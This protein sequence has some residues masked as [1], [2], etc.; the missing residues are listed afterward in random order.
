MLRRRRS[1]G[2]IAVATPVQTH[3][4]VP[5]PQLQQQQ[6]ATMLLQPQ[7]IQNRAST[8]PIPPAS[9][10]APPNGAPGASHRIRLVPHLDSRRSLRFDPISRDL[11]PSDPALRIGRFTDRSGLG[12]AAV[13]ALSTNKVAFKSK[14]VSRAHAEVFMIRDTKSSSGTFLN[15][16]R[17][18]AANT[19]SR[20]HPLKDGDILQLGV[21][22]QGGA[23][24]IYKSVKIRVEIGREWQS[25]ANAFN[26]AAL[27]NLKSLAIAPNGGAGSEKAAE[28]AAA[29]AA[30]ASGGKRRKASTLGIPDCCICLF[31]VSIRQ[32]LFIAPCSHTFHYKCLRPLLETHHPA[33]SCPL[34]RSFADLE[35]DVEVEAEEEDEFEDPAAFP[36]ETPLVPHPAVALADEVMDE[37]VL[38][39]DL[40]VEDGDEVD[41]MYAHGGGAGRGAAGAETEVEDNG[42]N[43]HASRQRHLT[44]DDM[45]PLPDADADE[46]DVESGDGSGSGEHAGRMSGDGGL[47]GATLQGKRKR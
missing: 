42:H 32:A 36:V 46:M 35:E 16:V 28:A 15:H 7:Q 9:L 13:N 33:F 44:E 4:S 8:A 10:A 27:K 17:L 38:A 47:G 19:E 5:L 3:P 14:V 20:P 41:E 23:E 30:A 18:S 37:G 21:D 11:K 22:Y 39:D 25:A 12:L 34:C 45:P 2:N 40:E 26:T 29:A 24:D 31:P 1:A 43:T 6:Q